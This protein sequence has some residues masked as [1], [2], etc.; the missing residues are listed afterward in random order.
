MSLVLRDVVG[1]R[2]SHYICIN[3]SL[4]V[5]H[6]LFSWDQVEIWAQSFARGNNAT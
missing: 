3:Y 6:H 2:N 1:S 5:L 4:Y